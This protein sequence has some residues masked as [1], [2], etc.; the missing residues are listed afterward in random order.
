MFA[1]SVSAED[2]CITDEQISDS[3]KQYGDIEWRGLQNFLDFLEENWDSM[4]WKIIGF[5]TGKTLKK[6]DIVFKNNDNYLGGKPDERK[7]RFWV[8]TR[9]KEYWFVEKN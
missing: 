9:G 8:L 1:P 3:I 5:V 7:Q 2:L 6:W 4:E